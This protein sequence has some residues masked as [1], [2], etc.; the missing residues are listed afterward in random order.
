MI[1]DETGG[2]ME[3]TL[4]L[5]LEVYDNIKS[6]I[7]K[8]SVVNETDVLTCNFQ[9]Y[10]NGMIHFLPG[11]LPNHITDVV[12]QNVAFHEYSAYTVRSLLPE[13]IEEVRGWIITKEGVTKVSPDDLIDAY[14][15]DTTTEKY[16]SPNPNVRYSN[17]W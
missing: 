1:F 2:V 15:Y 12:E 9:K 13:G 17:E 6:G 3:H 11:P 8:M 7:H 14:C 10:E 16:I 5:M 4:S